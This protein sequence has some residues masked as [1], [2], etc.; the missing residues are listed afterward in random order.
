M[1]SDPKAFF[2]N[3]ILVHESERHSVDPDDKG[4]WFKGQL[5]GSKYGVTGAALA[6]YRGVATISR[7]QMAALTED[8]AIDLG[9]T[10]YFYRQG[11][12]LLPWDVVIA[13]VTDLSFNAGPSMAVK[14]LQRLIGAD[15]DGK[16]GKGTREAYRLW[17]CNKTDE[18]AMRAWTKARIAFYVSLKNAKY[19]NGWTNRA[20]A[21][22]P[23]TKWWKD[24]A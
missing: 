2:R 1:R 16:A 22:L 20:N 17:R 18:E 11:I 5:V 8:E 4:N 9:L 21:F 23:G 12:D 24:N 15:D 13:G 19:E 14:V 3:T 6:A 7:S 10:G